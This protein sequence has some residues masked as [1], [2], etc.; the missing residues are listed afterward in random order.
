MND[1]LDVIP[2]PIWLMI[3]VV[4]LIQGTWL[5]VDARKHTHFYWF[6]GLWG[7]ISFPLPLILYFI[8]VRKYYK[9]WFQRLKKKG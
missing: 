6:W 9:R 4:L 8:F 5:F 7:L 3:A 1:D 2:W